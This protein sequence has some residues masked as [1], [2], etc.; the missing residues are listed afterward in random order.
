MRPAV[1]RQRAEPVALYCW[2]DGS[3]IVM[4]YTQAQRLRNTLLRSA[5]M[6]STWKPAI[7][8]WM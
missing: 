4:D 6:W 1:R 2:L 3:Y 5:S 7:K 8:R